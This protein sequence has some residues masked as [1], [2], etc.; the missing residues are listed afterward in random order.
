MNMISSVQKMMVLVTAM[1]VAAPVSVFAESPQPSAERML[2]QVRSLGPVDIAVD[3]V[4]GWT[5]V[6]KSRANPGG[7]IHVVDYTTG[8]EV[9]QIHVS[10]LMTNVSNSNSNEI[11]LSDEGNIFYLTQGNG[12][13]EMGMVLASVHQKPEA[14]KKIRAKSLPALLNLKNLHSEIDGTLTVEGTDIRTRQKVVAV[15]EPKLDGSELTLQVKQLIPAEQLHREVAVTSAL[16]PVEVLDSDSYS[17]SGL[18]FGFTAGWLTGL[19]FMYRQYF[20]SGFGV[21]VGAGALAS[22]GM[23]HA[24]IGV[25]VLKILHQSRISRFY[26]LAGLGTYYN[27]NQYQEYIYLPPKDGSTPTY[28]GPEEYVTHTETS[29][30]YNMGVGIGI[31][32]GSSRG[33]SVAIEVPLVVSIGTSSNASAH[34]SKSIGPLPSLSLIYYIGN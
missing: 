14:W 19:G 16:R 3:G 31:E 29:T 22:D 27:R 17:T 23:G 24:N 8:K 21:H 2:E 13:Q 30:R 5:F 20:E 1:S 26:A 7:L 33:V 4:R 32:L 28:S 10:S 34:K 11:E 15:M 25:E 6:Q 9:G 18:G 12:R